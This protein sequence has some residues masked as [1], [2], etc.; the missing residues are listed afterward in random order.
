M[1]VALLYLIKRPT[2]MEAL[3]RILGNSFLLKHFPKS[4]KRFSGL[5]MCR[6][7]PFSKHFKTALAGVMN[8]AIS[9]IIENRTRI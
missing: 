9:L 3:P 7:K 1:L 2:F 8:Y 5:K 4:V 6:Q